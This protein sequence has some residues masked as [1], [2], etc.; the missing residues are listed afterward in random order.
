MQVAVQKDSRSRT[1]ERTLGGSA[2]PRAP[3]QR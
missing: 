3:T 1:N 2:T